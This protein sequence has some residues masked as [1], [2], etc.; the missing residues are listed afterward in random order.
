MPVLQQTERRVKS[1][2]WIDSPRVWKSYT[3][4]AN[5]NLSEED[6]K[7]NIAAWD[8]FAKTFEGAAE[9]YGLKSPDDIAAFIEDSRQE[10]YEEQLALR[11]A[12]S[13]RRAEH[14]GHA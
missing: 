13:E 5:K 9:K 12:K 10:Y 6:R 1:R 3:E 11:K 7:N 8:K 14:A 4:V 2:K